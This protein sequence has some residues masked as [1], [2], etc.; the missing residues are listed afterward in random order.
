MKHN[1]IKSILAI[2]VLVIAILACG[3]LPSGIGNG[4]SS[5]APTQTTGGQ[6]T[7]ADQSTAVSTQAPTSGASDYFTEDFNNN[8]LSNYK[9]FLTSG[10][11]NDITVSIQDG[12]MIFDLPTKNQ[13]VY[14][15]YAPQTYDDVKIEMVADNRG[16]N[17]NNISLFC[18]YSETEGWY[19][20]NI[21]NS[22]LY[23]ILYGKWDSGKTHAS[24]SVVADGGSTKIKQGKATNKYTA[25]CKGNNL[26]LYINDIKTKSIDDN[27][28]VLRKGNVG[29]GVSSFNLLP[30]KVEVDSFTISQP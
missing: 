16:D 18:R 15:Y 14:E 26:S 12:F 17:D 13:W 27:R 4:G 5:S 11:A 3:P 2:T 8:D 24:Y 19:E 23:Q 30:V 25:I 7:Q 29:F 28:F 20:F 9:Q 22:G 10:N 1:S 6:P 21:A